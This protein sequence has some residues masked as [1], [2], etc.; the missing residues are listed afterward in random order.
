[1]PIIEFD[2]RFRLRK[3]HELLINEIDRRAHDSAVLVLKQ[4]A[5]EA[6]SSRIKNDPEAPS[7]DVVVRLGY[8]RQLY[9]HAAKHR[10]IMREMEIL[11]YMRREDAQRG[12]SA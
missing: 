12:V 10:F 1:L 8:W 4:I 11:E 2:A 9:D 3:L 6:K 5:K 7:A